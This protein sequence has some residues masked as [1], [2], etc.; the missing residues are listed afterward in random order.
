[1]TENSLDV[2]VHELRSPVA[3]LVAIAEAYPDADAATRSR[4]V[5]L[6][7]AAVVS[8]DGLLAA[9]SEAVVPIRIDAG[10][11][12][13]DAA[14]TAALSGASVVVET[15]PGLIVLGHPGRLRQAVDNLVAN[16][17]GHSPDGS[18]V[19]VS[20]GTAGELVVIAVYDEG[21]GLEPDDLD[22]IF[23]P[24]LRLT[25]AR[26]GSGL[27]LAVVRDVAREHGGEVTVESSP[28]GGSTF[29]LVLP[30]A[31]DAR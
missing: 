6:A 24:G 12:A 29:R 18:S 7:R 9:G 2:L 3:A 26:P 1:M 19:K 14:E 20:A 31:S 4:L 22:R 10:T 21:E 13:R 30:G 16:A 5:G 15:V 27:G 11:L 17:I 28:G 25:S 23:E 8:L